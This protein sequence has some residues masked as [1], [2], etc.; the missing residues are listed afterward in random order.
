MS[1]LGGAM[2][3]RSKR[4]MSDF[5]DIEHLAETADGM[6]LTQRQADLLRV[7]KAPGSC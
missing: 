2:I 7:G 6:Q 4:R 5:A 1:G 3:R